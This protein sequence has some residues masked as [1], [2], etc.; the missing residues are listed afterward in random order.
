MS[1]ARFVFYDAE[2]FVMAWT[3]FDLSGGV[4]RLLEHNPT[5]LIIIFLLI[6]NEKN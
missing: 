5:H 3:D 2:G 6:E 4:G 1:G